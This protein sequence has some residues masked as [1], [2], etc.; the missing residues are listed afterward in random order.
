MSL[1][2]NLLGKKDNK[3]KSYNDF[4]TWFQENEK[5]F[6]KVVKGSDNIERDFFRKISPKL[7]EL[8]DGYVYLTGMLDDNTVELVFTADGRIKNLIFIEELV[9]SA[10]S[11]NGWKFTAHKP[12]L[13]IEN[14]NI[15]MAGHQF[16]HEN[17]SFYPNA[18]PSYPDEIEITV[19]HTDLTEDNRKDITN[20]VFIFLDNF[21]GELNFATVIDFLNVEGK[22]DTEQELIPIK[23]L[24][25]YLIW[26]EKEFIE[27]YEG[28]RYDTEND[29]YAAFES[30]LENGNAL[31]AIINTDLVNWDSRTSHPWILKVDI[32]YGDS[33]NNGMPDESTYALLD[34]IE[35]EVNADLKDF[36]G[37]LNIGRQTADGVRE[38]YFACKEFR[39]ASKVTHN[40]I[41]KY[42]DKD[43]LE[44]TMKY[45]RTNLENV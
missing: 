14:V 23:K 21:L 37:Y 5:S 10:P 24:K 18:N 22:K 33:S 45:L 3:I 27:K 44:W 39:K 11:I 6:F 32:K 1:L 28:I 7:D 8:K 31:I 9:N 40:I 17:L 35:N 2:K 36:D 16:N 42:A 38:I 12:A 25:D 34:E 26:R 15:D 41:Q 4:W 19:V 20:G 13:D 43:N 29:N 30:R